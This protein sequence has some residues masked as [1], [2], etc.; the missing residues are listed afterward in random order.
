MDIDKSGSDTDGDR[1]TV[2]Y[3]DQVYDISGTNIT[4]LGEFLLEPDGAGGKG[5]GVSSATHFLIFIV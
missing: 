4:F 2:R 3:N 1:F 5:E